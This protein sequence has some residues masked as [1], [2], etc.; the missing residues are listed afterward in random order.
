MSVTAFIL[1][2]VDVGEEKNVLERV[3]ADFSEYV[4]EAW[5]TYGEYDLIIKIDVPSMTKL[6]EVVTGIRKVRG[7]RRTST[8]IA[9]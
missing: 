2:I 7:V 4:K 9:A 8:L 1:I 5:V 6:D 3:K